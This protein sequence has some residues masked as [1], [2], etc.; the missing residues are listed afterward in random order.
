VIPLQDVC[1][2]ENLAKGVA[3]VE[4]TAREFYLA[5]RTPLKDFYRTPLLPRAFPPQL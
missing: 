3:A 5:P 2:S 4:P 1:Y